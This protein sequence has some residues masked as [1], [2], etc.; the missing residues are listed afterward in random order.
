M[1]SLGRPGLFQFV[2]DFDLKSG[3]SIIPLRQTVNLKPATLGN[4]YLPYLS[5][6]TGLVTIRY[7]VVDSELNV[8]YFFEAMMSTEYEI[9]TQIYLDIDP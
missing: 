1:L 2:N 9:L 6:Y 4:T 7:T 8:I 5:A 3:T